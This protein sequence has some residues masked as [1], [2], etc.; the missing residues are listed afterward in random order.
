[1]LRPVRDH[2]RSTIMHLR[3][4]I[5][6]HLRH[7]HVFGRP[8][9]RLRG[10]APSTAA[11]LNSEKPITKRAQQHGHAGRYHYSTTPISTI[12]KH[13]NGKMR[14]ASAV[15]RFSSQHHR[16][17]LA[18]EWIVDGKVIPASK[19]LEH[20]ASGEKDVIVFLHGLLGNAKVGFFPKEYSYEQF[21][22]QYTNIAHQTNINSLSFFPC[23]FSASAHC[24]DHRI[25]APLPR[26]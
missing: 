14:S 3:P 19:S 17:K 22:I 8:V 11:D 10:V 20:G 23:C 25:Y 26:S 18:Y 9:D 2:H 13:E 21:V 24:P 1:M 5:I 7:N 16:P 4:N 6:Y 15:R 12:K